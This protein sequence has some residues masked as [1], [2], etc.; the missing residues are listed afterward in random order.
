MSAVQNLNAKKNI[1]L[2]I[3][4]SIAAYRS[5]ELIRNLKKKADVSIF[6]VLTKG[7][8]D[9]ITPLSLHALSGNICLKDGDWKEKGMAHIELSRNADLILVCPASANFI[10]RLAA[11][12]ADELA[13]SLILSTKTPLLIAPAMNPEMWQN[14]ATQDNIK[15]LIK[16]GMKI[17]PP[18]KGNVACGEYGV[19]RLAEL[20]LIESKTLQILG[21]KSNQIL[22]EKKIIVTAGPTQEALDPIRFITNH[23]SGKQG[24]AIAEVLAHAGA[25]VTLVTGPSPLMCPENV[26][27][28]RIKTACEMQKAVQELLPA[29]IFIGTAAVADWRPDFQSEKIKKT[30]EN[31]FENIKWHPN[32]DILKNL[33][34]S[35]ERPTL[36]IGFAAETQFL[37]ENAH[38]KRLDKNCDWIIANNVK[39]GVFNSEFN[40]ISFIS[41]EGSEDWP[42]MSKKEVA[43]KLL[44]KIIK[45]FSK[46]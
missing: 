39:E 41:S 28:R 33:G 45:F 19:G 7:G 29:D 18:N 9:F 12:M 36:L 1:L 40:T 14:P 23:A 21:F 17:I 16:R 11:G 13:T 43:E 35:M 34:H 42:K 32:P 24:Y 3:S 15:C 25:N 26:S 4:G 37:K 8:E 10:A 2:I 38:K 46:K 30:A 5:L 27:V 20:P 6:P 44:Q 22:S 31:G